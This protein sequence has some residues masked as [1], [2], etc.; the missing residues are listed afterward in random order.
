[1]YRAIDTGDIAFDAY[2][3][4]SLAGS[5]EELDSDISEVKAHGHPDPGPVY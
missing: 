3:D 5:N 4:T 1:M 2:D